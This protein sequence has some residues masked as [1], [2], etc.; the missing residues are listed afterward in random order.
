MAA[1]SQAYFGK[2]P[3]GLQP[4]EAALL[5]AVLPNPKR[6]HVASPSEYVRERA[7][8]IEEQMGLLGPGYL[9]GL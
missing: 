3:G 4:S 2:L 8:W 1:A 7:A 6:L 5:A 9:R